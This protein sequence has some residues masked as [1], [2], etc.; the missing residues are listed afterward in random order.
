M[1]LTDVRRIVLTGGASNAA[2][3]QGYWKR[4]IDP[5]RQLLTHHQPLSS[6]AKGS[7]STSDSTRGS[8]CGAGFTATF[9]ATDAALFLG[10][11]PELA[12]SRVKRCFAVIFEISLNVSITPSPLSAE[13]SVY[14]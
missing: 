9:D 10:G 12:L 2:Y 3:V 8:G 14:G 4:M 1:Q 13:D 7:D 5:S 6:I 11:A